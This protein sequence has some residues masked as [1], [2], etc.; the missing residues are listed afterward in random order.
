MVYL[1]IVDEPAGAFVDGAFYD[2]FDDEAVTMQPLTLVPRGNLGK[3]VRCFETYFSNE[4]YVH[5]SALSWLLP[6]VKGTNAKVVAQVARKTPIAA[7]LLEFEPPSHVSAYIPASA[8]GDVAG[9]VV[10]ALDAQIVGCSVLYVRAHL[11][12]FTQASG[13]AGSNSF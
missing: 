8:R 1:G 2:D 7:R 5:H 9:V 11:G 10:R 4:S 12:R 6:L 3:P 13:D